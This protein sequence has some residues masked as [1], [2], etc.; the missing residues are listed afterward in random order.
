MDGKW[1]YKCKRGA[2]NTILRYKA[3]WVVRG[4]QQHEG[5]DFYDIFA[6]VVKPISYKALL[7]IA[8]AYNLEFE[9]MDVKTAY[10]YGDVDTDIYITQPYGFNNGSGR[11]C[12]LNKAL[13]SLKQSPRIWYQY[14]LNFLNGLGY[15]SLAEDYSVSLNPE[16]NI[17]ITVYVDDLLIVGASVAKIANLKA[18]LSEKFHMSDL[19]PCRYYL[20]MAINR[21]R[22]NRTLTLSQKGFVTQVLNQYHMMDYK[23]KE[24]TTKGVSTPMESTR[25]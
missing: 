8:A 3:R 23:S 15:H 1:I 6:T 17:I 21:D 19:G 25:L 5:I 13:Y 4:F 14:L 9:Q 2:D 22:P 24:L 16:T 20:G 12:K 18:Q 10:L 11:V 7:A